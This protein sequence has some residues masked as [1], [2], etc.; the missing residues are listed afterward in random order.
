M[1]RRGYLL[2]EVFVACTILAALF[3]LVI[4]MVSITARERRATQRRAIALQQATNLL[5]RASAIPHD[6]LSSQRLAEIEVPADA[7]ALLPHSAVRWT[8]EDEA[9]DLPAKRMQIE[10]AWQTSLGQR[11]APIRL[12]AWSFPESLPPAAANSATPDVPAAE[13]PATETP[14]A[15][16]DPS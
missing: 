3:A 13:T 2:I 1:R 7:M 4:N 10:L 15:E 16:E 9:S 8:I 11:E 14:A 6:E 12:V 5:E